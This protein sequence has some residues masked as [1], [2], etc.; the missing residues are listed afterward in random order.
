VNYIDDI[1]CQ[2]G[3]ECGIRGV[4]RDENGMRLLRI[5]AVLA[6]SV[7][8]QVT[9]EHVHDA[10]SAW[11]SDTKPDHK[12]IVWFDELAPNVQSLDAKYADAI[13]K[14]AGRLRSKP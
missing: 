13:A 5:Y 10:W 14:V 2:I 7:G 9:W 12:S 8:E 4:D 11:R 6:L 3:D 1:A